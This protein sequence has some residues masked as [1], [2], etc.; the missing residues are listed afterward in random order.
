MT[1]VTAAPEAQAVAFQPAHERTSG[2]ALVGAGGL[3]DPRCAILTRHPR[4][5]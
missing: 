5:G 1:E 2:S 3:I 4:P